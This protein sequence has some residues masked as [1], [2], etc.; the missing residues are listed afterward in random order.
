MLNL[1]LLIMKTLAIVLIFVAIPV[2]ICSMLF[3]GEFKMGIFSAVVWF[4]WVRT[5]IILD[6]V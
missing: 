5:L 4:L 2:M 1:I 3:N 6:L